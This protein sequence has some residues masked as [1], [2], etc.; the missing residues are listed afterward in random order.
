MGESAGRLNSMLGVRRV[1]MSGECVFK[2]AIAFAL[3]LAAEVA[4]A[5]TAEKTASGGPIDS[6]GS[7][8]TIVEGLR[9]RSTPGTDG[10]IIMSLPKAEELKVA[11]R[12]SWKDT[13]DGITAPWYEVGK[14]WAAGWC[15]G[16]YL[17]LSGDKD[18]PQSI[19]VKGSQLPLHSYFGGLNGSRVGSLPYLNM[20][21]TGVERPVDI[22]SRDGFGAHYDPVSSQVLVELDK[23]LSGPIEVR[24]VDP[25]GL[26]YL[27]KLAYKIYSTN[28]AGYSYAK[29]VIG[30]TFE[31]PASAHPGTWR[32][33]LSQAGTK[34][35]SF[36]L[37]VSTT[38]AT[39]SHISRPD[40]FDYPSTVEAHHG[41]TL[42]L[43]GCNEPPN[44]SLVVA[45]YR[46][47]YEKMEPF[48]MIPYAAGMV[49]V[50]RSG[51]FATKFTIGLDMPSGSYKLATGIERPEIN[52]FDVYMYIP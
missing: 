10:Y 21:I 20:I 45:F 2:T 48:N 32:F 6:G 47:N 16:G 1:T 43:F 31:P 42:F 11:S 17:S 15:F 19:I 28:E 5:E 26:R 39:L 51:R 38:S 8:S 18:I 3:L 37:S 13:I 33:E 9:M 4:I 52:L 34:L 12:T 50:D 27:G 24:A 23:A 25:E 36:V 40:P 46:I 49:Q 30:F 41:D 44:S 35:R 29:T 7:A 22:P 14:G